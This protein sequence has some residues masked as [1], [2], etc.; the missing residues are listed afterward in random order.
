MTGESP[1]QVLEQ[2]R[3]GLETELS[4]LQRL[5]DCA[6]RQHDAGTAGDIEAVQRA[7]DERDRLMAGL[8]A[9]EMQVAP[10]RDA[11]RAMRQ[12]ARRLAAFHDVAALHAEVG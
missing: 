7:I 5:N 10:V 6:K 1:A 12:Q 11:L 2:Y 9:V 3:S 8:V 4:L